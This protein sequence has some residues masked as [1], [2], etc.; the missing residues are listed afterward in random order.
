[1]ESAAGATV[2]GMDELVLLRARIDDLLDALSKAYARAEIAE[3]KL[4]Y[5]E[6]EWSNC[7]E[8]RGLTL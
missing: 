7:M 5:L 4:A 8:E 3:E 1:M 2:Y 6:N